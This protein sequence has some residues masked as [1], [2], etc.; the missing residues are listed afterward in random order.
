MDTPI[1]Y[2]RYPILSS[3]AWNRATATV[4][5]AEALYLYEAARGWVVRDEMSPEER[6][7]FDRL[8]REVGHG[9][10]LG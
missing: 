6:E 5:R 9:V 10:F 8:V 3:L 2:A 1:E 4:T 7:L